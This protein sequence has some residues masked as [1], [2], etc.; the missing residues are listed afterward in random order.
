MQRIFL[1]F[2]SFFPQF[3]LFFGLFP[4]VCFSLILPILLYSRWSNYNLVLNKKYNQVCKSTQI[5]TTTYIFVYCTALWICHFDDLNSVHCTVYSVHNIT[6]YVNYD[7]ESSARCVCA[8]L[9]FTIYWQVY[10]CLYENRGEWSYFFW[11]LK[12]FF[13][14]PL[15]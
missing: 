12:F 4:W 7:V 9:W 8:H 5:C 10:T 3:F 6:L 13:V 14:I 2:F 1:S 11:K 15:F